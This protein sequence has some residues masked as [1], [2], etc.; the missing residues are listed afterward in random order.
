MFR[1]GRGALTG[2]S[3]SINPGETCEDE[4]P[5]WKEAEWSEEGVAAELDR[6]SQ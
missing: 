5:L 3:L 1:S 4:S 2:L 6:G